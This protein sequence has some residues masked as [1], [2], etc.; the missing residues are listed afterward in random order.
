[1]DLDHKLE[2]LLHIEACATCFD[3]IYKLR[4]TRDKKHFIFKSYSDDEDV[5]AAG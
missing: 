3:E 4:K 2:T 5:E 1:L